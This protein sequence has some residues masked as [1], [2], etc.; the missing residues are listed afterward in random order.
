MRASWPIKRGI[1][2][3]DHPSAYIAMGIVAGGNEYRPTKQ[4]G[5]LTANE[6]NRLKF[7]CQRRDGL[8]RRIRTYAHSSHPVSAETLL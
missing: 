5:G 1:C 3:E 8:Y 4:D 6:T 2:L 7:E